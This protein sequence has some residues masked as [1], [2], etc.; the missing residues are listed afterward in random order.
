M[1]GL[2]ALII[3]FLDLIVC[4][5]VLQSCR[6]V[7][8]KVLWMCV[9]FFLPVLGMIVYFCC[10]DRHKHF[11]HSYVIINEMPSIAVATKV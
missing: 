1:W 7:C 3:F 5:E 8:G 4:V 10:A 6:D 2:W 9:I 11:H